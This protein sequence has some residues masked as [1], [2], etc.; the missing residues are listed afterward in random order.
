M[1]LH[2]NTRDWSKFRGR[3]SPFGSGDQYQRGLMPARQN[4]L[5]GNSTGETALEKKKKREDCT[6]ACG[7]APFTGFFFFE[8]LVGENPFSVF[9][10]DARWPRPPCPW[11]WD[12]RAPL[13]A[14]FFSF[15][16]AIS[17]PAA[18]GLHSLVG[19][20]PGACFLSSI[21]KLEWSG[22]VSSVVLGLIS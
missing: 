18:F 16:L 9:D 14:V 4:K 13:V 21:I 2:A 6:R 19:Y 3:T 11:E 10:S 7:K 8:G 15:R 20:S 12:T 5:R 1:E 22:A 17:S